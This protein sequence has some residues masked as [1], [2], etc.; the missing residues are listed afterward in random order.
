MPSASPASA[1]SGSRL[2]IVA[3]LALLPATC[4]RALVVAGARPAVAVAAAFTTAAVFAAPAWG[5]GADAV[6]RIG[7]YTQASGVLFYPLA[8]AYAAIYL[9]QGRGL[10][11]AVGYGLL[12]G[13]CH[14]FIGLCLAPA[15]LVLLPWLGVRALL[16][17]AT[18]LALVLAASAFFWLPILIHPGSFGGFPSRLP[19]GAGLSP[20]NLLEL[21]VRGPLLDEGRWPV[22][23]VTAVAAVGLAPWRR[24]SVVGISCPAFASSHRC[25]S[26]SRW[27]PRSP[28]A[29]RSRP[30]ARDGHRRAQEPWSPPRWRSSEPALP[31]GSG[32]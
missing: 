4:A 2:S 1:W 6:F 25:S 13:L 30:C 29:T 8:L 23:S 19:D 10:G 18:L 31:S 9:G 12:T 21:F 24:R 16:R 15:L 32:P 26:R 20:S 27:R 17:A 22:L 5:L 7:L 28:P 11:R 14:P 3:P